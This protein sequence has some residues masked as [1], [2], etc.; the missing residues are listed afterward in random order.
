[1]R[2]DR[3]STSRTPTATACASSSSDDKTRAHRERG[4]SF[5]FPVRTVIRAD[6]RRTPDHPG[7]PARVSELMLPARGTVARL[8]APLDAS[9]LVARSATGLVANLR[10]DSGAGERRRSVIRADLRCPRS[11]A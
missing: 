8:L 5:A 1:V 2:T 6:D 9:A 7:L 4:S 3:S 10:P 11:Y